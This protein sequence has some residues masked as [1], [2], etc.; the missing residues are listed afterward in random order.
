[1][2]GT[3]LIGMSQAT[4]I[5]ATATHATEQKAKSGGK[6]SFCFSVFKNAALISVGAAGAYAVINYG[7]QGKKMLGEAV[8]CLFT[9]AEPPMPI[10]GPVVLTPGTV[11][12]WLYKQIGNLS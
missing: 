12:Y 4:A 6:L 11:I 2:E 7:E 1:M 8:K 5:Q 3:N 9:E 10:G